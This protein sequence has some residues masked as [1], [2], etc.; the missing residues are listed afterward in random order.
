M[1]EW[2]K[3]LGQNGGKNCGRMVEEIV[4]EWWKKLW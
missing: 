4:V 3:K 1:V 2:W